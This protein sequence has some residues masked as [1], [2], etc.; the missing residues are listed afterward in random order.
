MWQIG[1]ISHLLGIFSLACLLAPAATQVTRHILSQLFGFIAI[2]YR[3]K[4]LQP[5]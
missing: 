4:H 3:S 2:Q 5:A 1:E